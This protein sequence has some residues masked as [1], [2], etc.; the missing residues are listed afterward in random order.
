MRP[1]DAARDGMG[2]GGALGRYRARKQSRQVRKTA[3]SKMYASPK[4]SNPGSYLT[5]MY[6]EYHR[7]GHSF[8]VVA[9]CSG[10]M[11]KRKKK[12]K[13]T[14]KLTYFTCGMADI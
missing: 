6:S 2:V 8:H 12:E 11:K 7:K 13:T 5:V 9:K 10:C 3:R 4:H 1:E 14:Q